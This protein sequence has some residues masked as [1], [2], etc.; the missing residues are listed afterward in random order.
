[1]SNSF[2]IEDLIEDIESGETGV[3]IDLIEDDPN[4]VCVRFDNNPDH[5]IECATRY[6]RVRS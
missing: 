6:I 2:Q 5:V 4:F 1:M 3:V